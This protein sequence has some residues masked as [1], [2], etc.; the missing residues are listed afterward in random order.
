MRVLPRDGQAVRLYGSFRAEWPDRIRLQARLGPFL[1]VASIA[2]DAESTTVSLPRQKAYWSGPA[3]WESSPVGIA[4]GLLWLLCPSPLVASIEGPLLARVGKEWT[5]TGKGRIGGR[6]ATVT[7]R[8]DKAQ[9]EVRE[10]VVLDPR[11]RLLVRAL[12]EGRISLGGGTLP[13]RMRFDFADPPGT[14]EVEIRSARSDPEQPPGIFRIPQ[15]PGVRRLGDAD[16]FE[17]FRSDAPIR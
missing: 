13:R 4:A 12:R 10:I 17:L 8:L 9:Q 15:P 2:V 11:G 16:L 3:S 6:E 7:L 1:P 14:Y 5:L